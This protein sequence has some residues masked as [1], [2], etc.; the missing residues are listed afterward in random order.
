VLLR[1]DV[2]G[3]QW[4]VAYVTAEAGAEPAAAELRTHVAAQVPEYMVPGAFVVLERLPVTANGKVDRRA[5]PAPE[6]SEDAYVAPRTAMEELLAGIWAE[7][8]GVE[9]VGATDS[10]F[11]LG[12][13]S[14]LAMQ[15]IARVRRTLGV[16]VPLRDLFETPTVEVLARTVE[17]QLIDALDDGEL[18]DHLGRLSPPDADQVSAPAEE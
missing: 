18:A 11:E 8:L 17:E 13:H 14:I 5:L 7:V 10:F 6:R 3:Q 9:R 12:G 4:L 2:P 16:D 15:V 1:E